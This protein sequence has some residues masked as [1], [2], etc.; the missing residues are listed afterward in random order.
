MASLKTLTINGVTYTVAPLISDV[1]LL[2]DAWKGSDGSYYQEVDVPG[3]TSNSKVNMQIAPNQAVELSEQDVYFTTENNAG[4]VT[5]HAVGDKPLK[6]YVFQAT[7]TVVTD[8]YQDEGGNVVVGG[9]G[10]GASGFSPIAKVT[11]TGNGAVITITDKSGTTTATVTNGADGA[12]PKL[13]IGTVTTLN[14]GSNATA[15]ITGTTANPVLN[16]GIPK[17]ADGSGGTGGTG[18]AGADGGYYV[19]S[20]NSSGVL[21]WTASKT[22]MPSVQSSNI[23]GATGATPQLS[24]GT[25]TTLSAGSN[26]TAS[27]TGTTDNPILNLGIPKGKDGTNGTGGGGA[28]ADGVGIASVR[29]TTTS[30][31]DDGNNIITVTLTDGTSST[32]TVQNG[33]KGSTGSKGDKGDTGAAGKTPVRGTD[34]WT[35]SDIAEIKSYV[36]D[37]IL[38]GAW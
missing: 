24:I 6:N 12:T 37:A 7:V 4:V 27:I 20:V 34:Y 15:S 9:S 16:L 30:T 38:G 17:G 3:V 10:S 21:S 26:A 29:Q 36:D 23:K 31:A 1:V 25:V 28:G 14:A 11:Q 32:F 8:A 22:G 2:A 19:P 18:T 5:V 13:S 35:S 33:S